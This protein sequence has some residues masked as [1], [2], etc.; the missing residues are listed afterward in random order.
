MG[1]DSDVEKIWVSV[2]RIEKLSKEKINIVLSCKYGEYP[3]E[4][5]ESIARNLWVGDMLEAG[6]ISSPSSL[7]DFITQKPK[8]SDY[9][10]SSFEL[11]YL[12]WPGGVYLYQ[13]KKKRD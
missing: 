13:N 3:V 8:P 7:P 2:K 5:K 12:C 1:L 6:F 10:T 11:D 9:V 4:L